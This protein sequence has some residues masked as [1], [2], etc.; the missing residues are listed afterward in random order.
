MEPLRHA[1]I[2]FVLTVFICW[3][4]WNISKRWLCCVCLYFCKV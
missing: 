2:I 4:C 3:N 1:L